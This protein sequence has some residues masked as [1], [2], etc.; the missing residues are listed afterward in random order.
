MHSAKRE[1]EIP[2]M[3]QQVTLEIHKGVGFPELSHICQLGGMSRKWA[4][5]VL[6]TYTHIQALQKYI[7]T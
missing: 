4:D 5:N 7:R 1:D 3:T 2:E 6:C